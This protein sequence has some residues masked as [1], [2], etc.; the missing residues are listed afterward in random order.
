MAKKKNH[1]W[2]DIKEL[3]PLQFM[4][5]VAKLFREV[6]GQD[7]SGLG[8]FTGWID[9]GGYYHWRVAQQGLIHLIPH[10]TGQPVPRTPDARPSGKPL[11]PSRPKS[12][13][14]P[15]E[16]LGSSRTGVNQPP[17]GADRNP[18]QAR[19]D[20]RPPPARAE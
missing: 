2:M 12:R 13:L 7:L 5:Y 9:L 10:L 6:N 8:H 4:P 14:R 15:W 17:V 18:P 20:G 3:T 16:P 1:E 19:V 11:H